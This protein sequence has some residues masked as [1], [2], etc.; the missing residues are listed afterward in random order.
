[1]IAGWPAVHTWGLSLCM[2]DT[3]LRRLLHYC[4]KEFPRSVSH[5]SFVLLIES[6]DK[7]QIIILK[8]SRVWG[9]KGKRT[10]SHVVVLVTQGG[11][12]RRAVI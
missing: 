7:T 2:V 8:N 9:E 12:V 3:N 10:M 1:M 11:G 5:L 6:K 4:G